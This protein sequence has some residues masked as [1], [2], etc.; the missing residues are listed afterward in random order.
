M[1]HPPKPSSASAT[2]RLIAELKT[3]T[4]D[5][6]PALLSLGPVSESSLLHWEA[7]LKGPRRTAYEDGLWELD[8][9]LPEN[10]PMAPPTVRFLTQCCHPNIHIQTGEIC[11]DLLKTSWSPAYT[12]ASTLEAVQQLLAYPQVDSPLN[13]DIA[14]V[15]KEGDEMGGESLIRFW[16]EERRWRGS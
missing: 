16:C 10:Y 14:N 15:L 4:T 5:P 9:K 2:K 7:V 13:V 11:L 1:P 6:S 12:I 3:Q 8:I